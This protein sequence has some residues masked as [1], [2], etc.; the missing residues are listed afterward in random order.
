MHQLVAALALVVAL[1]YAVI[2]FGVVPVLAR[3]ALRQGRAVQAARWGAAAFFAGCAVTHVMI[4]VAALQETSAAPGHGVAVGGSG[5]TA[6]WQH[7]LP[8]VAQ[9]VGGGL[10]IAV[11][12]HRLSLSIMT[13]TEARELHELEEHLRTVFDEAPAGVGLYA[14]DPETVQ[15][16]RVLQVNP[17]L[18]RLVGRDEQTLRETAYRD[19]LV[20]RTDWEDTR[21]ALRELLTGREPSVELE[22]PYLHQDGHEFWAH[23]MISLTH[24]EAGQPLHCVVQVRDV[25]DD[26]HRESQLRHLAEHDSLTGVFNR[27]RF[28]AELDRMVA[29]VH[30]YGETAALLV[31]DLD[32][33]KF[34]ND[35][36]GHATGDR[37][38]HT[39]AS[40]LS[41]RLRSTDVLGRL[42]GDEF[43][44]LLPH[45]SEAGAS[46]LAQSLL[47]ALRD[48]AHVQVMDRS[49]RAAA[50]IGVSMIS[51]TDAVV[52]ADALL[53]QADIA[54]Y[55]AK[56][57]GRDRVA[58]ADGAVHG[59]ARMRARLSWSERVRDALDRGGFQLWE[60]PIL[61]L[62]TGRFDRSE[63]LLR[64]VDADGSLV[65]P[66]HFLEVAERF[67]QVQ[68]IDSWVFSRAI[69]LLELRHAAGDTRSVEINLSGASLTDEALIDRICHQVSGAAF[70]PSRLIVEVT[71]TAAVGNTSLARTLASRLGDAGC[72]FALDDFGSG[73]GSFYYLKHL[74]FDGVKIDGEFVKD[75]PESSTDLVMLDAIVGMAR[76]LGKEVTAEFVQND[77]T[78]ALL[79]ERG[80]GFAQGFHI[81]RPHP[82]PEFEG[83]DTECLDEAAAPR[84]TVVAGSVSRD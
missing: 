29:T 13:K 14:L 60:Q 58:S 5:L 59:T 25:T 65:L 34:V 9:V 66:G 1:Q 10:F 51:P 11:A 79:R 30:R 40:V 8:H 32:H 84:P 33:F 72:R 76:G 6:L 18:C 78:I 55:E 42:G 17:A 43:G 57:T 26:R 12:H 27:H 83:R 47:Q 50:S 23:V 82:V 73:F 74:H 70:D 54:M 36:Y 61:D 4:A 3:L 22:Q 41:S 15:L 48:E 53:A 45:T 67:G 38:L 21:D 19:L 39:V 46:A 31:V 28:G 68:G 80:V 56:E 62:A 81:A 52:D 44:V 20:H 7:V 64:M 49:V 63:L 69:Q 75:L 77:A 24:D 37:L 71:E 35:T 2:A 16:G